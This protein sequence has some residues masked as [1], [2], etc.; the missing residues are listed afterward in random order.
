M[1]ASALENILIYGLSSMT[2]LSLLALGVSAISANGKIHHRLLVHVV[3]PRRRHR[4]IALHTR[5]WLRHLGFGFN[6]NQIALHTFRVGDN[7]QKAQDSIPILGTMLRIRSPRRH[8]GVGHPHLAGT[9]L[10]LFVMLSL[11]AW[12]VH[13]RVKPE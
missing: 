12:V 5:P 8:G 11:A 1:P 7:I 4:P 6:L 2:I 3:D 9:C 10:A 13:R